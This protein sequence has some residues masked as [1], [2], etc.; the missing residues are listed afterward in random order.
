MESDSYT[1]SLFQQF[2][3]IDQKIRFLLIGSFNTA[4]SYLIFVG[5]VYVLTED[6]SN[7]CLGITWFV[8]SILSFTLHK[9]LVFRAHG[10]WYKEYFK[11]FISCLLGYSINALTLASLR[12]VGLHVYLAQFIA[13]AITTIATY[14]LLK[15]FTFKQ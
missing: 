15:L 2:F 1:K 10:V 9:L 8:T 3:S 14:L 5:L 12:T 11:F 13:L 6:F 7:L 4:V